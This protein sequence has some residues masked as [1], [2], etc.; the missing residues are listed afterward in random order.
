[1]KM[2][3][4][5]VIMIIQENSHPDMVDSYLLINW[6]KNEIVYFLFSQPQKKI[7]VKI[8]IFLKKKTIY[9]W[10][11]FSTVSSL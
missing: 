6:N 1:M 10:R 4:S 8:K 2:S 9:M 7:K 3:E 11:P 5:L